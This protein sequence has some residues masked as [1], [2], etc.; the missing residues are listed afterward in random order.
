MTTPK[1]VIDTLAALRAERVPVAA[2]L[3]AI[4]LAIDNLSRA[5]SIGGEVQTEITFERRKLP[6]IVRRAKA[7]DDVQHGDESDASVRRKEILGLIF[8]AEAGMT[9]AEIRKHTPKMNVKD[10]SNALSTLKA[11]GEIRRAG[12]MWTIARSIASDQRAV[13]RG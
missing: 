1:C 10:R 11:K 12:N 7:N 4:D 2:R 5:W 6:R 13:A 3:D 9:A 8:E